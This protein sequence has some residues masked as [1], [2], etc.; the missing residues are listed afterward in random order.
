MPKLLAM[1]HRKRGT[2]LPAILF[3][4]ILAWIMLIPESSSFEKLVEYFSFA[5]WTF[6]GA[7][8]AALL[9]MRYKRPHVKRPYKVFIGIPIVVL[10]CA[11]Y[12]V[13]APFIENPWESFG[14][15]VFILFGLVLYLVFVKYGHVLFPEFMKSK[16]EKITCKI[17][18]VANLSL[19]SS[20][21]D[22]S[23]CCNDTKDTACINEPS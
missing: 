10:I 5:A 22:G 9:W 23:V 2:P 13:V 17:Q 8:I 18:A 19:P 14:A 21:S 16:F 15:M 12:L 4:C 6:Y 1:I 7:T 11:V 3:T 20:E